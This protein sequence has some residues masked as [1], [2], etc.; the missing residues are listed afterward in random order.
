MLSIGFR[1]LVCGVLLAVSATVAD[2]AAPAKPTPAA[3]PVAKAVAT[4]PPTKSA[5]QRRPANP[6]PAKIPET[7]VL[8]KHDLLR[9]AALGLGKPA[10]AFSASPTA[11]YRGRDFVLYQTLRQADG[12]SYVE[13]NGRWSYD[14][15]ASALLFELKNSSE[16]DLH[17]QER[18][19]GRFMAQNAFGAKWPAVHREMSQLAVETSF[20]MADDFAFKA[21]PD[22][23][24]ALT[25]AV[26][27]RI[28]G[29]LSPTIDELLRCSHET[30]SATVDDPVQWDNT[31]CTLA[32]ELSRVSLID[33]RSGSV[34]KE[35]TF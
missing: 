22:E 25:A 19:I 29:R 13:T 23:A 34:L 12:S 32:A 6:A 4:R 33:K 14:K 30:E 1:V 24:R 15:D 8:E 2:A 11:K 27:L 9:I 18:T 28:E 31:R 3:K 20:H 35:W 16:F 17:Y 7:G 5:P 21:S 26:Y 10:D